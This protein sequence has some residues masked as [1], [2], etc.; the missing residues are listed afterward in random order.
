MRVYNIIKKPVIT[1]KALKCAEVNTYVFSVSTDVNKNQIST[2]LES[3]YKVKV[4]TVN[5]INRK[6]KVRK[7]GKRMKTVRMP[8]TK[9]AYVKLKEGKLDLIP[10]T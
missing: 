2:A 5:I 6:G 10:Q 3:L 8:S 9:L 7:K 4:D 1:E